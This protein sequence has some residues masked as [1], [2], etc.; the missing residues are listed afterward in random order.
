MSEYLDKEDCINI[1]SVEKIRG[2]QSKKHGNKY[3]NENDESKGYNFQTKSRALA[4][5][6][7]QQQE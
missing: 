2:S 1:K 7:R 4:G 3:K 5:N 6:L